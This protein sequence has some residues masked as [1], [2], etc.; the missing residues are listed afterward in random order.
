VR[1]AMVDDER[2]HPPRAISV[3]LA[4][5][6][7]GMLTLQLSLT[8]VFSLLVWY[9]FA[10]LA[11]ALALLG[12]TGGGIVVQTRPVLLSGDVPAKLSRVA[13]AAA[14]SAVVALFVSARLPF[15]S[16]VLE[17]PA[18]FALFALLVAMLLV[19]FVLAG[20][21]VAA[22]LSSYPRAIARLYFADLLGS[23]VGCA[24]T[25][26]VLDR[27]GGGAGGV[28]FAATVFGLAGL[29]YARASSATRM[30]QG[31]VVV[32]GAALLLLLARDPLRD[33]FY[34]PN[35]KLYPRVPRELILARRC[36]S[37]A[38]VDFFQNPLHWGMWGI[39]QKYHGPLP[40]QIGVVIDAWAITSILKADAP[41]A[42]HHPALDA[43]PGSVPHHFN[44]LTGRREPE[45]LVI[46]A[47]GGLDVRTAL[48]FGAKRVDA[49]DINPMIVGAVHDDWND[50]SGGLYRRPDVHVSIAEGRHFMRRADR[51]W[52]L[53]QISGVDT[54]AASQAGAF[55]LHENYLYTVEAMRE[56]L[57]HLTD[58]GTLSLTRWLYKPP[59]QTLRLAVVLDQAMREMGLPGASQRL[60][61]LAAPVPDSTMDFSIMLARRTP[62]TDKEVDALIKLGDAMGFYPVYTPGRPRNNA[63][64]DYFAST[65]K[66]AFIRAYP[67]RID[68]TTDDAPFF[69][70][71]NRF[72][73]LFESRDAIFGA[74]SGPLV[75]LV[76]LAIVLLL[77]AAFAALPRLLRS[78]VAPMAART[79]VYFVAL[80]LAYIGVELWFVP[81]FVLYLGHPSHALSVVLFA[82][83]TASGVGSALSSRVVKT[84]RGVTFVALGIVAVL[85]FEWLALPHVF[86]ATLK[87]SFPL[88][89]VVALLLVAPPA[90]LMGMPFPAAL[91]FATAR[92]ESASFVARAW[93]LNGVAS[94][95]ASV[96]ATLVAIGNGFGAVLALAACCYV[97]AAL[98]VRGADST[99]SA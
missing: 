68:A 87:L 33:P 99:A 72:A 9:H 75:L 63:F 22:T 86:D 39:S 74:A 15:G 46:G 28:L 94:V 81:R 19:P 11:I 88:R 58:D 51:R 90:M 47:G 16:S 10:F 98:A 31:F 17:S 92:G 29:A 41:G 69:F 42:V 37:L 59:R 96:G 53:V 49:V 43:L 13:Y 18:Q 6:S 83:L 36:S 62:F 78:P 34:L 24:V 84:A 45:V 95:V 56:A 38:C 65:D 21:L 77:A 85:A 7:L 55:A 66:P 23:G 2:Q 64:H 89:V 25:L 71:H 50:F 60:V 3:G 44:R 52:D 97:V 35:A 5:V 73:R 30:A 1:A 14:V 82:M 54:Y 20:V 70:E 27:L 67:F 4:L 79:Q 91:S 32:L 93:V 76:T 26:F 48:H 8:R 57:A 40:E 12:F 61:I 80:G